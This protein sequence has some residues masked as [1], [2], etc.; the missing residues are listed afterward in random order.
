MRLTYSHVHVSVHYVEVTLKSFIIA[1][2]K[3]DFDW[4]EWNGYI[5]IH[6][7]VKTSLEMSIV[8]LLAMLTS[9]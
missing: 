6:Q 3:S 7:T 9:N 1:V 2:C 8:A 4:L 5:F